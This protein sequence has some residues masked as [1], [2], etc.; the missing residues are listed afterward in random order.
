MS[1]FSLLLIGDDPADLS[2]INSCLADDPAFHFELKAAATFD[3]AL[4]LLPH[5]DF[6]VVFVDLALPDSSGLGTARRI[7]AEYSQAA[8]IVLST[9]KN[10][11]VAKQAVRYGAEDYIDKDTLSPIILMKSIYYSTDRKKLR[12]EKYDILSDLILAFEKIDHLESILP[13]CAGCKK[14]YHE[15]KQWLR[16]DEYLEH[17][18]DLVE[19]HTICPDCKKDIDDNS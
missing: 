2:L 8:V 9:P 5:Y 14:I 18:P 12:Q 3:V 6:D 4:S 7:I 1:Y 17:F 19:G 10:S 11:E 16:L 13:I 15:G